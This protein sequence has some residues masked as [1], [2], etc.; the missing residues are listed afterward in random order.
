MSRSALWQSVS[1]WI[2]ARYARTGRRQFA[3]FITRASVAG[4]TLGVLVLTVVV[5]VMNGFDAELKKRILGTVPHVVIENAS[6][7]APAVRSLGER[8][9]VTSVY[10]FFSGAGMATA[11]GG[12]NPVT[13]Y[14]IDD[15]AIGALGGISESLRFTTIDGLLSE[16]RGMLMGAPL[17]RHLGLL[18]GDTLALVV[19]EPGPGGVTPKI[20]RYRL[21]G[22][23]EIGAELDYSLVV[24]PM[25][26]LPEGELDALG[27]LGVRVT[28]TDPMA[29]PALAATLAGAHPDWQVSSWAA[30]YGELF[31]AVRL[32]K[33][34]MFLILLMVVAVAAF[35]IV[36]GQSMSV[37]DKRADI[38]ILR[39]MGAGDGTVAGIFLLQ[40]LMISTLGIAVGLGVGVVVARHI[41][42]LMSQVEQW[43]GFNL[44]EGTYF[45]EV[46]SVVQGGDLVVIAAISLTL[47]LISA[48]VPARRAAQLNPIA[49]LHG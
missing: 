15:T 17:A 43:L 13:V 41:G 22:L 10:N 37:N 8:Q 29:A 7:A 42:A 12:V 26:T 33:V 49:G 34:L 35:N 48:W 45:V 36:S 40:G 30:N 16:P 9:G 44:L 39:T 47:C 4:L 25:K 11:G 14:G 31:Q 20:L 21:S 28:L 18:P 2:A 46:P 23:F 24:V 38:A 3:S 32:E 6:M 5:S 27:T 19:S 1:W